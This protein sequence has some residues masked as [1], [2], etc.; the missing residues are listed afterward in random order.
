MTRKY[1][2]PAELAAILGVTKEWVLDHAAGRR[3][4]RIPCKRLSKRV[5]RFDPKAIEEWLEEI[6]TKY[7]DFVRAA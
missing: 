5:I 6:E 4:P 7:G 2:K 3:R 1:L